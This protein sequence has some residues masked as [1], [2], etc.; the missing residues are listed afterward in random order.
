VTLAAGDRARLSLAVIAGLV[1]ASCAARQPGRPSGPSSPLPDAAGALTTATAHCAGLTTLTAELGLSG[2]AGDQKLRGRIITG[3]EAG[4]AARLEGVAPF[5]PPVFVLAARKEQATLLLL[6]DKRVL[7]SVT[8][9]DVLERLTGLSMG[10]DD[11]M[12]A[13]A[14]CVGRGATPGEGRQWSNGWRAVAAGEGRTVFV[15]QVAGR[16][17]IVAADTDRWRADYSEVVNGFPR[18]V[19]LRSTDGRVDVSAQ[20]RELEI[21]TPIDAA[22]FE[23][24]IPTGTRPMGLDELRSVAPLRAS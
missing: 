13:I 11:L 10:A 8:V 23:V 20:V 5:G 1:A 6:R 18:S 17:T 4:G 7:Q 19:R 22:A 12:Q 21:N 15:R 24:Q 9:A 3:L 14:G 2:R 16:W